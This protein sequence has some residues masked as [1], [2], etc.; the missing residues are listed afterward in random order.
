[1]RY[2]D[3]Q[4]I[5]SD[6]R[7]HRY[8]IACGR[9]SRKAMTLYR[10]N[11]RLSQEMFT[12]I[13]CFEVALRNTIDQHY[14]RTLGADWLRDAAIPGARFGNRKCA[15]T[16]QS[17]NDVVTKLGHNYT[18]GKVV[19]ELGFGFW[20]YLFS[21]H[22]YRAAGQTLI[23]VFPGLPTSSA[24]IQYNSIFI[25]NEL[26][27]INQIRNRIAHH[28]AICFIPTL[29]V[30]NTNF[31]RQHYAGMLQLFQWMHID[32]NALLHGLDHVVDL[33]DKIDAL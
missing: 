16:A 25:F 14:L 30:K 12:V 19:S 11:L 31:A 10:L 6:T 24:S 23:S 32:E 22:Q 9:N 3:F 20:R 33:C 13:S 21:R 7:M 8:Y 28:E 26:E 29:Y 18:H 15:F 27:K 4:R 17:I 2:T 5:M 1:M